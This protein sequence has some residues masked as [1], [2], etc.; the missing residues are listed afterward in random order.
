VKYGLIC[1]AQADHNAKLLATGSDAV[2]RL[3]NLES[4]TLEAELRGHDAN[5]SVVAVAWATPTS[6]T[7]FSMLASASSDGQIIIWRQSKTG[8]WQL[9]HKT[10]T[11]LTNFMPAS[12]IAFCPPEYGI[13]LA[14]GGLDGNVT[15]ITRKEVS[16]SAVM[17]AG[18]QWL[19]KSFTAHEEGLL[20]AL[21]WAPAASPACLAAG[22]SASR[23]PL[24][25]TRRIVTA[26]ADG[27][28]RIWNYEAAADGWSCLQDL[29]KD[30]SAAAAGLSKSAVRDV[31]WRSNVGLPC[32]MLATCTEAGTVAI[33][34]QDN[35]KQPWKLQASW[36]VG[37]D[38]RRL[39]WSKTG[40]VLAVSVGEEG[41]VL[42]KEEQMGQWFQAATVDE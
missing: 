3:W 5:S 13:A 14:V 17:P 1:D 15:V 21:S 9:V 33:W 11:N 24:T 31:A 20:I 29:T 23:M 40:H 42:F 18:E 10:W 27:Q 32:S 28:V 30:E 41:C 19:A 4:D 6:A 36:S 8:E 2:V 16:V 7:I 12:K 22:P 26:S 34:I 37:G 39:T 38:A 25:A 35:N